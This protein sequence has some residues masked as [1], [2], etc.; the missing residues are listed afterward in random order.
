VIESA[1]LQKVGKTSSAPSLSY[2]YSVAGKTYTG[3][4]LQFGG[5]NMTRLEAED[6]L[7]AYPVG[8]TTTVRYDPQRHD[9]AVLRLAADSRGFLIAGI[10]IGLAFVLAGLVVAFAG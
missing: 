2:T 5:L 6:V 3:K 7:A 10:G 8:S 9:F 1:R 4:R